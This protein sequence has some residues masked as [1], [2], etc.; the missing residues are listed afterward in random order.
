M[1]AHYHFL[2]D[3]GE[4]IQEIEPD[5][6]VSR[7]LY[8][9]SQVKAILF[10]FAPGQELS[11]HTSTRRAMLYFVRGEAQITLGSDTMEARTGAYVDMP[12][13]L[14]HSILAKSEVIMLLLMVQGPD[15]T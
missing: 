14:P 6:I 11:E 2:P 7:S 15:T 3:L 8:S 5:T 10:G 1:A 9:D 13:N 4:Q 12:P